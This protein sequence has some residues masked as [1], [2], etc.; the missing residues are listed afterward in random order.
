MY[1]KTEGSAKH[2]DMNDSYDVCVYEYILLN[3]MGEAKLIKWLKKERIFLLRKES[4]Q[5]YFTWEKQ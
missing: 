2:L 4:E 5:S 3:V 1:V